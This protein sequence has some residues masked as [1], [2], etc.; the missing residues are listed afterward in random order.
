MKI[1]FL[2]TWHGR[3]RDELTVFIE[4]EAPSTDIFCFQ[5]ADSEILQYFQRLLPE[6]IEYA[7]NKLEG[8]RVRFSLATYIK[9]PYPVLDHS[10]LLEDVPDSGLAL[11]T[12]VQDGNTAVTVANVHG[13]AFALDDKLDTK[14]R[15]IQSKA[16]IGRLDGLRHPAIIGGD[17][18]LLPEASSVRLF[19]QAG[20]QDLIATHHISTTR[21]RLAWERFP[22]NM[23]RYADYTFASSDVRVRRFT[24]PQL[25]ISDHL[26]LII[27]FDVTEFAG[28][29][30]SDASLTVED[31]AL[32]P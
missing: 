26:P 4:K 29:E 1:V 31:R 28:S 24:V 17:F 11:V 27:E 18:N 9:K 13:I 2:N 7:S 12:T 10:A 23:Q 25:E 16:I 3:C 21:N 14:G 32:L 30:R 6:F 5:E 15:L 20:Y 19:G 8:E 22:D